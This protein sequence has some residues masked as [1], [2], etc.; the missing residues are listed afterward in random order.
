MRNDLKQC[1]DEMVMIYE[2]HT[3]DGKTS[4]KG[5]GDLL[6]YIMGL[7]PADRMAAMQ[8]F[9]ERVTNG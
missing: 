6:D 5:V 2:K 9:E 1:V 3:E 8:A 7:A 4:A